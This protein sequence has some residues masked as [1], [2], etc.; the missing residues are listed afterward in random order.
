MGE[1]VVAYFCPHYATGFDRVRGEK[2]RDI[3][4]ALLK[5]A[6]DGRLFYRAEMLVAEG[7]PHS[8]H[9][10]ERRETP[11]KFFFD[12]EDTETARDEVAQREKGAM[13]EVCIKK[14][15]EVGAGVGE[16]E[17]TVCM[18]TRSGEVGDG[19]Y[20]TSFRGY[21]QGL[22]T[23][24]YSV[25]N[26]VQRARDAEGEQGKS[27]DTLAQFDTSVYS[28][29]RRMC[30]ILGVK[31]KTDSRQLVP[32]H[33][34]WRSWMEGGEDGVRH[35]SKYVI[36]AVHQSW[37]RV[38]VPVPT[39]APRKASSAK[40]KRGEEEKKLDSQEAS[41][42]GGEEGG[43]Q[44]E[45]VMEVFLPILRD[46]GFLGAEQVGRSSTEGR[47]TC[48]QFT[49][50]FRS[51][52][53]CCGG[54][55]EHQNW[56]L[57]I[58]KGTG[59]GVVSYSPQC[60]FRPIFGCHF[61]H[62]FVSALRI[63]GPLTHKEAAEYFM[64]SR[65]GTVLYNEATGSYHVF[66]EQCWR[67]QPDLV[68]IE[69]IS[70][71]LVVQLT[72]PA[73]ASVG[74]WVDACERVGF[75]EVVSDSLK[76]LQKMIVK[77]R[78]SVCGH[79]FVKS[80]FEYMK[81]MVFA[82]ATRFDRQ[83]GLLHFENGVL[84][85]DTKEFR[86]AVPGDYNTLTTGYDY[87][88]TA[89]E[90]DVQRHREWIESVYP[91]PAHRE[92]AQRVLGCTLS[93]SNSAKKLFIFTDNGGE[94][95]G[96]NGKTGVFNV[97]L[98]ALGTYG[99]WARKEFLYDN[100]NG[101]GENAT[102]FMAALGSKRCVMVEEVEPTKKLAEGNVK[103]WTSGE[104]ALIPVRALYRQPRMM[105]WC[106][107]ILIGCNHGKFPR[108][109]AYDEALTNRFLTVP[110]ISHFTSD[111]ALVDPV[112]LIFPLD[113]DI[114]RRLK[115][116]CRLAHLL[117]C[118]EG[119]DRFRAMGLDACTLPVSVRTFKSI[120]LF[121]NTPVYSFLGD[122][123]EESREPAGT[124]LDKRR[125]QTVEPVWDVYKRDK[126][127][128]KYLTREQFVASFKVYVNSKIKNSFQY[129]PA[130]SGGPD[131]PCARGFELKRNTHATGGWGCNE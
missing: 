20:K 4:E 122:V 114:V 40:R 129:L 24:L 26:A 106:G 17:Y 112:H 109:D 110:H 83:H 14:I 72:G 71:F 31:N 47:S 62:P 74:M 117:W 6:R 1:E 131:E 77:A 8:R 121:K 35:V 119:Y 124:P 87:D 19:K 61:L 65:E 9:V 68:M 115:T 97:H 70:S 49:C 42:G 113:V 16:A 38:V 80:T 105:E 84:K 67:H 53:P 101:T 120:L 55:H 45:R 2:V 50:A 81:G 96:N 78:A 51:S 79:P 118:L 36:Q 13:V 69:A 95:G 111:R 88:E 100:H 3:A 59:A 60:V 103:E 54:Q 102:P 29:T 10:F 128:N 123:L 89:A 7:K 92:V 34:D 15:M 57:V 25:K 11:C 85:L 56:R 39:P 64:D 91:D 98:A 58:E 12:Y 41:E 75:Q 27:W 33:E 48:F 93:G 94:Y 30:M 126:R 116:D 99:V 21:V 73:L 107:K 130:G 63:N 90:V 125:T 5:D 86:D 23:D 52:C 28:K 104:N 22:V 44:T 43:G 18:A 127:S 46:I 66:S 37:R 82:E 76:K 108:F 32:L